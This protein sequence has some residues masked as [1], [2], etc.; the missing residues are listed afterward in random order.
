[1]TPLT[2]PAHVSLLT[3]TY[4]CAHGVR[5]NAI[6]EVAPAARLLSEVFH[7]AGFKT[8]AFVGCY[9]L[10]P[11]FGLTQ[12]FDI[13]DAPVATRA[14]TTWG[15]VERPAAQVADAAISFLDGLVPADPFFAWVHFYDPHF[16]HVAPPDLDR[17]GEDP[18]DLEI[19]DCDREL[20]RI[21]ERLRARGLDSGLTIAVTS[22]H[23]EAFEEHG[24][25]THGVFLYEAT[26][27]V[28]L[29]IA[30]PPAGIAA[31][32]RVNS[33]VSLVD[34][35]ATLLEQAGIGREALP[36]ARTA[37]LSA[38][39]PESGEAAADRPIYL[40]SFSAWYAH[41]WAPLRGLV[42]RDMKYVEAPRPE[43]YSLAED[44]R[45]LDDRIAAEPELASR[46]AARLAALAAEHPALPWS[47]GS[48]VSAED[49]RRFL[50]L[51]YVTS[52][53]VDAEIPEG[54][55]DPKDRIG[56]VLLRDNVVGLMKR[57]SA[58][59]GIDGTTPP[60]RTPEEQERR[61]REGEALL[62]RARD[63][64]AKLAAANPADTLPLTRGPMIEL[65]LRNWG[66]AAVGFEKLAELQPDVASNHHNLAT[67][68]L[69]LGRKAWARA[70][71][72]KAAQLDPGGFFSLRWLA[73][74]GVTE[75][76]W[77]SAAW[78]LDRTLELP[79][80]DPAEEKNLRGVRGQVEKSLAAA[81]LSPKPPPTRTGDELLPEGVRAQRKR[82][83]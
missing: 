81:K 8:G 24:E 42:W 28:P 5:D 18:Y 19:E 26:M 38:A 77:P 52:T 39:A 36:E 47:G 83:E 25:L 75:R 43:L 45:E 20:R 9:V 48:P 46:L 35:A 58:L 66:A 7:D 1:V 21:L 59:L 72:E 82:D 68:Y 22:D 67:A 27:R 17:E 40:E 44:P 3:G 50:E 30:P 55:P 2:L 16:P 74:F 4:P 14:G 12:G 33:P 61:R 71:M 63:E 49:A 65:S 13:Y 23:G 11:K 57:A 6:F 29:V 73:S 70:E 80:I 78:W 53:P 34:V 10:D 54:L 37:S 62:R 31:G 60:A 41:G 69:Q 15:V 76:D 51:G 56:D 64:L 32:A 79:G